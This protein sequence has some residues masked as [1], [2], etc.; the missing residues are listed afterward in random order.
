MVRTEDFALSLVNKVIKEEKEKVRDK[1]KARTRD[2]YSMSFFDGIIPTIAFAYSKAGEKNIKSLV[3]K[4]ESKIKEIKDEEEKAYALY[5]FAIIEYLKEVEGK[6]LDGS[7]DKVIEVIKNDQ[8]R[9]ANKILKFM[10]WLK[11]FSEAK[12]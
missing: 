1:F 3:S 4:D 2:M 7:I 8:V 10:N 12:I 6:E 11:L 5:V 9:L